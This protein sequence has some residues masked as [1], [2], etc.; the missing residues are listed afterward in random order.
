MLLSTPEDYFERFYA[1][2]LI[3][4]IRVL[5]V[6]VSLLMP[7]FYVAVTTYHQEMLPTSLI[8]SIAAQREGVPF[9]AFLE[10]FIMEVMFELIRE[11]GI[12]LPRVIGPAISIVGG[13]WC[14]VTLPFEQV[15]YRRSW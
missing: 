2:T 6:F 8:L 14:W 9:P 13:C 10:A 11:A 7:S 5:S 1:G 4:L 3:R 12:R 15:S